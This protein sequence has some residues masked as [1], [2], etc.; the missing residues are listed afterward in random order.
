MTDS[1]AHLCDERGGLLQRPV[2]QRHL[3]RLLQV[4]I[5]L[6]G[7]GQEGNKESEE[8]SEREGGEEN[9]DPPPYLSLSLSL[10]VCG[11]SPWL[12]WSGTTTPGKRSLMMFWKSSTSST[13]N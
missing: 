9:E 11:P 2:V 6:I 13:R 3:D 5:V 10:L 12:T 4:A 1:Y 8:Q 7:S